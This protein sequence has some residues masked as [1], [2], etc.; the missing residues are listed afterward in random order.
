M[1]P[2]NYRIAS[3]LAIDKSEKLERGAAR[4]RFAALPFADENFVTFNARAKVPGSCEPFRG[5]FDRF[6]LKDLYWSKTSEVEIP[7]CRLVD[8]SDF[9]EVLCSRMKRPERV[10]PVALVLVITLVLSI[11]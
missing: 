9:V 5:L 8:R 4:V 10:A 1:M 2:D 11:L 7:H 3:I 6:R